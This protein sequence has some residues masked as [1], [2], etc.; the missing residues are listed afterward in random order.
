MKKNLRKRLFFMSFL[1]FMIG[2]QTNLFAQS[3]SVEGNVVDEK[4]DPLSG[5]T[6]KIKN[7]PVGTITNHDGHF[8]ISKIDKNQTLEFSYI[9]YLTKEVVYKDETNLKVVMKE[10][11]QMLDEV[12]VIGYG[13]VRKGDSTGAISSVKADPSV[14]GVAINAQDML[15]GKVS[16][17][18]ITNSGGSPTGGSTIR[19]RGGSSLSAS[20]DP[21]IIIDGVPIDNGGIGG[22]GNLLSSINPTDIESFTV[23]KDA[24]ATAIY[25][26]RASNGV[27]LI[28]TKKGVQGKLQINYDGN[29]VMNT[30]KK[31]VKVFG[32]NEFR[33]YVS[34][35][36][37]NET[38]HDDV[39]GMLGNA[40]TNWQN[41]IYRTSISTEHNLSFYGA[42]KLMPYRASFGYNKT[43]GI[44]KTS[45]LERYTASVA[46]SPELL[47][48]HL[49]VNV[50]GK[51]MYNKNRFANTSAI[52][53]AVAFDPTQ[54]VYDSNSPYGGY[55]TWVDDAGVP[56]TTA[57]K[58][59][60]SLLELNDNSS[61]VWNFIGNVQLDYKLHFLPELRFNLNLGIDYSDSKGGTYIPEYAPASFADG[62]FNQ[63]WKQR[64]NNQ[65][66]EFYTQYDKDLDFLDSH[67][68][69][70]AGYS[71]QKYDKRATEISKR[72]SKLDANGDPVLI[73]NS[74]DYGYNSLISFFGRVN[75]NVKNKYMMTFTLRDDGSSRFSKD[76]RWGIFPAVALAWRINDEAFFKNVDFV[77]GLKLRLG[78][79]ITGQ[80]DIGMGDYPYLGR[81]LSAVGDQANY[82]MGGNWIPVLKPLSYNPDLKWEQTT[83][84]NAGIDYEMIKG[85]INGSVD[86]YYRKT[87]DLINA[88]TKTPAGTNFSE[89]VPANVG[90][91]ENKGI[92]FTLNA[93]PIQTK[94][95]SL[96]IGGN[97]A[98]N[99][100]KI[101]SLTF[102]DNS[103]SFRREGIKIQKAGYSTDMF[104]VYQQVYDN[105]YP[106]EGVYV[107]QNNDG[108][109]NDDDLITFHKSTP[110]V[111]LGLN[112]KLTWKAWDFS[113]AGH[114]TIGN[115]NYYQMA[116]DNAS[117]AK[118][119]IF[120]G[121]FILNRQLSV[122]DTNYTSTQASSSY[123]ISN[124][125]FFRIDNIT[126]G[127]SFKT[128][129]KLPL[130]GRLYS[131]VQN[132]FLFT[133]YKG[134]EPEISG[135]IDN[136]F[137]P[138]PLS[139]LFGVNL[140][141]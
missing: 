102:G 91:L 133:K 104:Y 27:I 119:S 43:N 25:G 28:T 105:G 76:N 29:V 108:V 71:W 126:L 54:P 110:D 39:M 117:T 6:V 44:L 20:N 80:Q 121:T 31:K 83:T 36:F 86:V 38:N 55:T 42:T 63:R 141:F 12:V 1:L 99:K 65:I 94:D 122:L 98:Y 109:R 103:N 64:R 134:F 10:D 41:E 101:L 87:K 124:A 7:S 128:K 136:S 69:V 125:S 13:Q 16:G 70:M 9:T 33:S 26:S 127:W 111:I 3:K 79:G 4:G 2:I 30:R 32:G 73:T 112:S 67:F 46:L 106:L 52:G 130:D 19:I 120:Q 132:P 22:V 48:K 14:R 129:G 131:S 24:S 37:E 72:I 5:V 114:G 75:Y 78:W 74:L 92:E 57:V 58:N 89:Y 140:K 47:E 96:E 50:N 138:R 137:Y 82:L 23:L 118:G 93:Y 81:Y 135:G 68:D 85:K 139:V 95:L 17:L 61:K 49:K 40:N 21:L 100:N 66:F 62:G 123:Y 84:W 59:P 88:A 107:D 90:E 56:I 15:V 77:N 11:T 113:F 34:K 35:L 51:L 116:A 115:Y 60:V 18:Q 45:D 97:I 53:A 8:I